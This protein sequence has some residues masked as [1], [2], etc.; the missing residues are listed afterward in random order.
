MVMQWTWVDGLLIEIFVVSCVCVWNKWRSIKAIAKAMLINL[1]NKS[2][3]IGWPEENEPC[4]PPFVDVKLLLNCDEYDDVVDVIARL[5]EDFC[6][7]W[8]WMTWRA[9]PFGVIVWRM[10]ICLCCEW[11]PFDVWMF[12]DKLC[13]EENV[14][15]M[16]DGW[17]KRDHAV[18]KNKNKKTCKTRTCWWLP[19]K[20]V[21]MKNSATRESEKEANL[22]SFFFSCSTSTFRMVNLILL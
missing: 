6:T 11:T 21:S 14:K 20:A 22:N 15:R 17:E 3:F 10:F 4:P 8:A 18:R 1:T 5:D 9:P 7:V 19:K 16:E 12:C 2:L 13:G